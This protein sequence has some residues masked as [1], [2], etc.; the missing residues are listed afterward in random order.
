M[1]EEEGVLRGTP[2]FS[3]FS[4]KPDLNVC[5]S[6]TIVNLGDG[7]KRPEKASI[8]GIRMASATNS[9]RW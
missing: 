9:S 2:S 5:Q 1:A 3:Y 4:Y 7:L 6:F 8:C